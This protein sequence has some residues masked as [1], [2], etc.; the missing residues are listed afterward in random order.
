[1]SQCY[2]PGDFKTYFNENMKDLGLPVPQ[3]LFDNL[4]AAVANAGLVLD[5]L[6]TLGTGATMAE[7]IKATT[8]LEKLKVA[9]SLGASFY[10]GA[11]IGSIAV[12]SGRSVGCGNRVSDMFVFLQQNNL[13]FDGWNSFYARNPEILDKSS[14]FRVAYRS[15]AL[16]GSGVYA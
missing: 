2:K 7:V 8:G 3:T 5:A 15:K 14:R 6:E 1:M 12:A 10:V 9:A 4:N 11:V 13:A 16:V